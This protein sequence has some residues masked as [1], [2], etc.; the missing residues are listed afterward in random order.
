MKAIR[1]NGLRKAIAFLTVVMFI[2]SCTSCDPEDISTGTQI[3]LGAVENITNS[4][5]TIVAYV[6]LDPNTPVEALP[7]AVDIR[8]QA[9]GGDWKQV[10][11]P[12]V[13][14][15]GKKLKVIHVINDLK[16]GTDY[17]FR[18]SVPAFTLVEKTGTF[19]T[20]AASIRLGSA[21]KMTKTSAT[22]VAWVTADENSTVSFHHQAENEAWQH[23]TLPTNFNG[24]EPVKVTMDLSALK[25]DT[26]YLFS[27]SL[28]NKKGEISSEV[29]SFRTCA[30]SDFDGNDYHIVN[31]GNQV[32]L[33]ENFKGT[34]FANGDPIPNI[35]EQ[36]A[37]NAM[38]TPAYCWYNNDSK[39]GEVYGGLYNF[40]VANDPR[41]LI[42]GF[43]TPSMDEWTVLANYLGGADI[44]GGKMKEAGLEHW[45]AP[46]RGATNS[47]GFTGLPGGARGDDFSS[48]GDGGVFWS[49]TAFPGMSEVCFSPSLG[50][51]VSWFMIA[52]GSYRF[53]GFSLR[54]IKN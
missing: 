36:S 22:L 7:L 1:K 18:M 32:W 11:N 9:V 44:A 34:H 30:V 49:T 42:V 35:T 28:K 19:K 21:E 48:L 46:N 3:E 4:S 39:I 45:I 51:T 50:E 12:P 37:W 33:Q 6:T 13:V 31:I 47:S 17:N 52:G 15:F 25:V 40:Y 8:Y 29:I 54:L 20:L 23:Q 38:T 27:V 14:G 16:L 26:K 2:F 24:L 5:A 53:D 10:T 41:G 43:H